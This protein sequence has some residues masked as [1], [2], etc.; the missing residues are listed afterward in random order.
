MYTAIKGTLIN[1]QVIFEEPPPTTQNMSVVVILMEEKLKPAPSRQPGS[2]L[3]LGA[4]QGKIY[5]LPDDFND[6]L[7]D[8][9]EYME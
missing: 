2:L 1:G 4:S 5:K 8:L 6:P 3:K 9:Q 7:N